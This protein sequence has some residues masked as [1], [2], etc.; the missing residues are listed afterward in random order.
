MPTQEGCPDISMLFHRQ[1]GLEIELVIGSWPSAGVPDNSDSNNRELVS[2]KT[3]ALLSV[4]ILLLTSSGCGGANEKSNAVKQDEFQVRMRY[5]IAL[6]AQDYY[7]LLPGDKVV[8]GLPAGGLDAA[9]IEKYCAANPQNVGSYTLK[10]GQM[11]ITWNDGKRK[12]DSWKHVVLQNGEEEMGGAMWMKGLPF[13]A[14]HK[15][16]GTYKWS[17][18]A[19]SGT[20]RAV[21]AAGSI[22]L[23]ADGTFSRKAVGSVRASGGETVGATAENEQNGTY[24]LNGYTMT[25]KPKVG[26]ATRHTFFV[27]GVE[28]DI[29]KPGIV[30]YDGSTAFR[31]DK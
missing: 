2:M 19:G 30:V 14:G 4:C 10:D 11:N 8:L 5:Q 6:R 9:A 13:P 16:D 7:I 1:T 23:K 21:A 17:A 22:I 27:Q 24:E 3:C 15:L 18:S 28:K 20:D 31:T 26:A 29:P 12:P 25:L